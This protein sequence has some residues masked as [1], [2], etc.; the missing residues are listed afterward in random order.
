MFTWRFVEN[1]FD[2]N[3][4]ELRLKCFETNNTDV[5]RMCVCVGNEI[6][7]MGDLNGSESR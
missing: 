1:I 4:I 5:R 6:M 7:I 3:I 2:W